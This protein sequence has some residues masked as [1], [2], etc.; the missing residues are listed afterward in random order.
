MIL[1]PVIPEVLVLVLVVGGVGL[2]VWRLVVATGS[3]RAVWVSR[4]GLVLVC[5][6][7]LL[8]PGIP[9][10][11]SE[12]LA[13]EVDV[14]LVVDATASIV[15]EDWDGSELRLDGVRADVDEIVAR[16]PGARFALLTFDSDATV[17]VP[18]TT[19]AN[20]VISSISVLRPEVTSNSRGSSV[21]VAADLLAQTLQ[22]AAD[23]SPD[24][25]R[26]V[27][28]L[29][30]GEQTS[31]GS[32]ESFAE[33]ADLV[34][35]GAV[36][37]YGTSE[38]GPMRRTDAGVGGPGE[39][40]E[41][42]GARAISRIDPENLRLIADDLGVDVVERSAAAPL[43][44]PDVPP[45]QTVETAGETAS[46]IEFTWVLAAIAA[47]LLALELMRATTS[48]VEAVRLAPR[49]REETP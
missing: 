46:V 18:L 9:G 40:I 45:T 20:A 36:L 30:D 3:E 32:V 8:R 48:L 29:G 26:L 14:V 35:G 34:V 25:S 23:L 2:A 33:S 13:T 47:L 41:Y 16:Y 6:L 19:D 27:F 37:G 21:G 4:V 28:Y 12:T 17:R 43:E 10:G 39:Y 15:A 7:V 22:G 5:G 11:T 44:L 38:G 24:R 1:Q 49:R 31:T 42:E